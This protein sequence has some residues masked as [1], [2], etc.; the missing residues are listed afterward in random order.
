MKFPTMK[1]L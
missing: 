1:Y